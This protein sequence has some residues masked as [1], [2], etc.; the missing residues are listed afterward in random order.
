MNPSVDPDLPDTLFR[1]LI[2]RSRDLVSVLGPDG[3]LRYV[4]PSLKR[5]LGFEPEEK[6]QA[7]ALDEVHPDDR[8]RVERAFERV[9]SDPGA[10]VHLNY[11]VAHRDGSWRVL[12]T[13]ATNRLEDP[14]IEGVVVHSWDVTEWRRTEERLREVAVD[15]RERVKELECLY[16]VDRALARVNGAWDAGLQEVVDAVPPGFQYPDRVAAHLELWDRSWSS[17][18]WVRSEWSLGVPVHVA[19]EE[20]GELEVCFSSEP[21]EGSEEAFIP[22]EFPLLN[23]IADRIGEAVTRR[24]VEAELRDREEHFRGLAERLQFQAELLDAVGQAVMATDLDGRILYWNRAAEELYGWSEEETLGRDVLEVTPTVHSRDEAGE[25]METLRGGESWTGEFEVQRKDGST[26]TALVTNAPIEDEEGNLAGIIGVSTDLT[27]R[28][29]LE[30]RLRRAERME[31]IGRLAGGVAHDFNNLLTVI[32]GHSEFVL[33]GLP[34][35]SPLREDVRAVLDGARRATDL[36]GQLLAFGRRQ[37]TEREMLDVRSEIG[38]METM[39]RRLL[40]ERIELRFE[41]DDRSRWVEIDPA[42]LHQVVLNLAVNAAD[43]IEGTG[44]VTMG[45]DSVELAEREAAAMAVDLAPGEYVRLTVHDTGAGMPDELIDRIFEPFFTTKPEEQGTG[46]GLATVFGIARQAGGHVQVDSELG[47]GT[48]FRILLPEI[49]EP[50]AREGDEDG[51]DPQ[52]GAASGT[53][54]LV[55]DETS[56]RKLARRVLERAGYEVIVAENGAQALDLV[57]GDSE[58]IDVVVSDVVMPGMSGGELMERMRESRPD[59]PVVLV[60]GYS[61]EEAVEGVLEKASAF[62]Q[63]PFSPDRIVRVI[64]RVLES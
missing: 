62:V 37:V 56:V 47:E 55:E 23:G 22:E 43:A 30:E 29:E 5:I 24:R 44:V 31:A 40:P 13:V 21:P 38:D 39:L 28:L 18:G 12:D 6:L 2:E 32:R 3:S 58:L 51:L 59:L 8:E 36:V 48:T 33:E 27:E 61:H 7:N 1:A 15:L 45:L 4:S 17:S 60:S 41:L 57:R 52:H 46:L 49:S 26:F 9:V 64:R 54:L 19:G 53:V 11:R 10:S 34:E 25:I 50:E 35:E 20:A 42:Q 63:K 16:E 14:E